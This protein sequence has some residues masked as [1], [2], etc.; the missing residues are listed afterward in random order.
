M[1]DKVFL[2]FPTVP[3]DVSAAGA[4]EYNALLKK[5]NLKPSAHDAAR[6]SA[7]AAAKILVE[8]L[9]LAGKDLSREGLMT[10]LEGLYEFDTG[11]T[12]KI[13]FGP[14]RRIGALGAYIVTIDPEKKL[15]PASVEWTSTD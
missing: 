13:S 8:G 3:T 1:K 6:F 7:F 9:K 11:L 12:P 5:Y 4:A 2:A 15:F 10:A 14:N